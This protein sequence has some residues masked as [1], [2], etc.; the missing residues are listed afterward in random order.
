M[1]NSHRKLEKT[2][3]LHC[4]CRHHRVLEINALK[5]INAKGFGDQS[6]QAQHRCPY[7]NYSHPCVHDLIRLSWSAY[8]NQGD[9]VYITI[10]T[11]KCRLRVLLSGMS[12]AC[13]SSRRL[14][15]RNCRH[16]FRANRMRPS[17][18]LLYETVVNAPDAPRRSPAWP[19]DGMPALSATD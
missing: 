12:S 7:N 10:F 14:S 3:D 16:A 2:N 6:T 13:F 4:T 17:L 5:H 8:Y 19:E 15:S 11:S 18:S 9:T 1:S